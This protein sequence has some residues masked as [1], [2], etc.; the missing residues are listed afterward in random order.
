MDNKFNFESGRVRKNFINFW[1]FEVDLGGDLGTV[2]RF[3]AVAPLFFRNRC[4]RV[5]VARLGVRQS[6]FVSS[7]ELPI[8]LWNLKPNV[9]CSDEPWLFLTVSHAVLFSKK[10]NKT[11]S[12][13]INASLY[14]AKIAVLLILSWCTGISFDWNLLPL[15][16]HYQA[17]F[18]S[19]YIRL[20]IAT[21]LYNAIEAY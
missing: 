7:V 15:C 17:T 3:G 5:R 8:K 1:Y 20:A 14:Y 13:I 10:E 11:S 18:P 16:D 21:M 4:Q 19:S 12:G 9:Q 6:E 2:A